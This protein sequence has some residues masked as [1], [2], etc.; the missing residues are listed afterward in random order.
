MAIAY[1]DNVALVLL[2][3]ND[4][5]DNDSDV[6][7]CRLNTTTSARHVGH[8]SDPLS[9]RHSNGQTDRQTRH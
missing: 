6:E 7:C 3:S 5:Q 2:V 8:M 4:Q 1:I 9:Y